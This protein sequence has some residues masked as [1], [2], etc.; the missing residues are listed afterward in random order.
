[1]LSFFNHSLFDHSLFVG[2]DTLLLFLPVLPDRRT[3]LCRAQ[4]FVGDG[5]R[6]PM[7]LF[8]L[9]GEEW[10]VG[11]LSLGVVGG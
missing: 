9:R 5:G 6:V 8:A 11:P 2:N 4:E 3:D 10:C 7:E 1:M